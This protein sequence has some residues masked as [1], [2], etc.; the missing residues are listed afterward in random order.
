MTVAEMFIVC[1]TCIAIADNLNAI[2]L[3]DS[4]SVSEVWKQH[5]H[6]SIPK[7]NLLSVLPIMH[8]VIAPSHMHPAEP[9]SLLETPSA[10]LAGIKSTGDSDV[11]VVKPSITRQS[12]LGNQEDTITSSKAEG[13]ETDQLMLEMTI[14][15]S[16][17][18]S[19]LHE[20][21]STQSQTLNGHPLITTT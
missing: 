16:V 21:H 1:H 15:P 10:K 9:C 11:R 4:K 7:R 3:T 19:M 5:P 8:V 14:T 6:Q 2:G 17:M 13:K 18:R 12:L 20:W